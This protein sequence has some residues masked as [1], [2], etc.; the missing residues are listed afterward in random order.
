MRFSQRNGL[1]PIPESIKPDGMPAPLRN[2]LW[3]AF[4]AWEYPTSEYEFLAVLWRDFFKEPIDSIPSVGGYSG[5]SYRRAWDRIREQFFK[6]EWHFVYDFLEFCMRFRY[7]GEKLAWLVSRVLEQELAAYC[8]V[9]GQFVQIT[10]AL[11]IS[12][13]ETALASNGNIF[14]GATRHI[15]TALA[16]LSNRNSPDY[17]NCI[18]ES[19][20]AVEA[21]AKIVS[22]KEK[23]DLKEALAI[24]EKSG[25]LHGALQKSYTFLYA[26]T[27]DA[28]GIRHALMDEPNLTAADAKYFLLVCTSF[29]NYLKTI[30]I[31]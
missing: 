30:A 16:M 19:I 31:G 13:L 25:K 29:V 9:D 21:A 27:S 26:Y 2:S 24:L 3:N 5:T 23:A 1:T 12:A 4:D 17:R 15:S 18:K 6:D 20:S 8:I 22:G 10:D 7:A 14:A 28:Q 11:E